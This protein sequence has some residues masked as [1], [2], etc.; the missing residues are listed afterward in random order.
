MV[1]TVG[2]RELLHGSKSERM[3]KHFR[4]SL[5]LQPFS[6]RPSIKKE[7][8]NSCYIINHLL[9]TYKVPDTALFYLILRAIL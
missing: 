6:L 7:S 3:N 5:S 1:T 8:S 4:L 2:S 9:R